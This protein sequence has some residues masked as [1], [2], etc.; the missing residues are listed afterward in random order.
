MKPVFQSTKVMELGSCAFRQ[1]RAS[2]SHC[3]F[4]HGY[5]LKAK[6]WFSGSSLDDKNWCVDFGGLKALKAELN[7]IYDHTTT[8]AADDPELD[9]FKQLHDKGLI[10]LYIAEKGVGIERAAEN[11]FEIAD[12]HVRELT[13]GRCWVDKVEVFEH[14]EN[15]ATY[16]T[17]SVLGLVSMDLPTVTT[18]SFNAET[19]IQPA[20]TTSEV[21]YNE[22]TN[23]QQPPPNRGAAVGNVVSQGMGNPFAGTSWGA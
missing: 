6:L 3:R 4:L 2:H 14:E 5:Q 12:R 1:W 11:V 20:V 18:Y 13:S 17:D 21:P 15:S 9:T 10:Q 7:S 19:E 8:V 22:P 23:I 16:S